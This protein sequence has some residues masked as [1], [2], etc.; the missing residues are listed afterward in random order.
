MLLYATYQWFRKKRHGA[1]E[2]ER[3]R[4]CLVVVAFVSAIVIASGTLGAL[5]RAAGRVFTAIFHSSGA[6]PAGASPLAR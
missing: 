4:A 5:N 6:S 1:L 3:Q 2:R